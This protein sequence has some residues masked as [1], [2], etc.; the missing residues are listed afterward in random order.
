MKFL[1]KVHLI[2]YMHNTTLLKHVH[3]PLIQFRHG[4]NRTLP[5]NKAVSNKGLLEPGQELIDIPYQ[6]QRN[7]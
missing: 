1:N 6:Y 7:H 3:R 2:R 5:N 4:K